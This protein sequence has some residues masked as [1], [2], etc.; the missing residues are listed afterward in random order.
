MYCKICGRTPCHKHHVF[1][2]TANR[3]KSEKWGMTIMLCPACHLDIKVGVHFN[4][5]NDLILK[6]HFERK[7]IKI[8]SK[9]LFRKEFGQSWLGKETGRWEYN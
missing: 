6:K 4:R 1:Y 3:K 9:E 7:F 5:N 8:H 2:G